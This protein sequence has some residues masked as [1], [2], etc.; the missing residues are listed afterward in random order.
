MLDVGLLPD[1]DDGGAAEFTTGGAPSSL[2]ELGVNDGIEAR[3]GDAEGT[4]I[5]DRATTTE[6]S[7]GTRLPFESGDVSGLNA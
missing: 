7:A 1:D 4:L 6:G 5:V 3:E 2:G